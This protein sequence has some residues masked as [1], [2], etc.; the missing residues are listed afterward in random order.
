MMTAPK[1]LV[2]RTSIMMLPLKHKGS[3]LA[4]ILALVSLGPGLGAQSSAGKTTR[5]ETVPTPVLVIHAP[6]W[7]ESSG[8]QSDGLCATVVSQTEF[9]SLIAALD[10]NMPESNRLIL[11]SE[12]VRLMVMGREAEKLKL[13]QAA[14]FK[15]LEQF[16]RLQLLERQLVRY[17]EKE[18]SAVSEADVAQFYQQ[19]PANFE[20][21]SFRKI[22]IPKQ[23]EWS[24]IEAAQTIQQRALKGEDFDVL[25]REIWSSQG[26][27]A[28]SPS[29]HTGTLRRSTLPSAQQAAFDLKPGGISA[30]IVEAAGYSIF[31]LEFKK[32]LPLDSVAN[33]IRT[34]IASTRLEDRLNNLRNAVTVSVDEKYFG[35]LPATDELATH[36]GLEHVGPHLVPMS[37]SERSPR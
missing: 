9:D 3:F 17:L 23:R 32:V 18:S 16:T 13:D 22:F 35:A 29:T 30:P 7:Q 36:H 6:C 21:G 31:K 33:E 34:A 27:P 15:E 11:A 19:H 10:P 8:K 24:T 1:F 4:L 2:F 37:A 14:S 26:R 25:Q 20:E 28:G 5:P 12:Y